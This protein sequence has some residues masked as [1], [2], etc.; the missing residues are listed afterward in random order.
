[1]HQSVTAL[2]ASPFLELLLPGLGDSS[3]V[4]RLRAVPF[5]RQHCWGAWA[6]ADPPLP[7][8]TAF[9]LTLPCLAPAWTT[10]PAVSQPGLCLAMG[11]TD[12]DPDQ[13][14]D[15]PPSFTSDLPH[16]YGLGWRSLRYTWPWLTSPDLIPSLI[17]CVMCPAWPHGLL[18]RPDAHPWACPRTPLGDRRVGP[19]PCHHARLLSLREQLAVLCP[20][21]KSKVLIGPETA[22]LRLTHRPCWCSPILVYFNCKPF[23]V[24]AHL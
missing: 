6:R 22:L 24:K 8:G 16:H 20:S 2:R 15:W 13:D 11:P 14:T 7:V 21:T 3:A 17:H 4:A 18:V 12:P 1:M 5:P 9:K 23:N 19:G 10:A